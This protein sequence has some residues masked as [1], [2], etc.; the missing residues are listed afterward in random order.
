LRTGTVETT[1]GNG[2]R[3][4]VGDLELDPPRGAR[5]IRVP[6]LL[7][8]AALV[9]G[10]ALAA[11]LWQANA[12][13][14]DPVLAVG[15]SVARGDVIEASDV[16]VVYVGSDQP[17]VTLSE[18]ETSR[19]VGRVAVAD[20]PAGTLLTAAHVTDPQTVEAGEGVVGLALDPGQFP[21][22]QLAPGDVVNVVAPVE[23]DGEG[24]LAEA[25]VVFA[26]EDLGGPGRRFV[27]LRTSEEA[28]NRVAAAAESGPVRLV[29]VGD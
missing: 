4:R 21:A 23:G 10:F 19:V 16:R 2:H 28:A 27:S 18:A 5:R 26:V 6:E 8:G 22:M 29:L 20:L 3:A 7:V 17:L 1:Q 12:T 25:A 11:V 15:R 24:V 14:R 13:Q 9:V